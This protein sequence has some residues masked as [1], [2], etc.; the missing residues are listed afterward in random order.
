[1]SHRFVWLV[2]KWQMGTLREP[3]STPCANSNKVIYLKAP[4]AMTIFEKYS[5]QKQQKK[6]IPCSILILWSSWESYVYRANSEKC[7]WNSASQ[8]KFCDSCE[9]YP[10][11]LM[12][13]VLEFK[14]H[15]GP[16][17]R[18]RMLQATG[19]DLHSIH[20]DLPAYSPCKKSKQIISSQWRAVC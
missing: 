19:K 8:I 6:L 4:N 14:V 18:Y 3:V 7:C 20:K 12:T 2:K 13:F 5:F 10:S 16:H 15:W 1:M 17:C 9:K 11:Y